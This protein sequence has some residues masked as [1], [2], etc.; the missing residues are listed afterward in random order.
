MS[1]RTTPFSRS[2]RVTDVSGVVEDGERDRLAPRELQVARLAAGGH[3]NLE[4][5]RAL[6]LARETIQQAL[7]RVYSKLQVSG[8]AQMAATLAVRGLLQQ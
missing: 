8:R 3:N 5:A 4:I 2:P 6:G 1:S 7:R